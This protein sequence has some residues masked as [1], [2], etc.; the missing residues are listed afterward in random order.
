[1]PTTRRPTARGRRWRL[2]PEVIA[3]WRAVR[4]HGIRFDVRGTGGGFYDETLASLL[5]ESTLLAQNDDDMRAL[6]AA[7]EAA[8]GHG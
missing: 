8:V 3:R 4:P 2:S 5:G 1:M 7:L 6:H